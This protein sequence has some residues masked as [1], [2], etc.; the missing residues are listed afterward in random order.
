[1]VVF[2]GLIANSFRVWLLGW[3]LV[4]EYL[5][6]DILELIV[7]IIF[8]VRIFFDGSIII[9]YSLMITIVIHI[10]IFKN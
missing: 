6:G 2:D 5:F 4:G 7:W 8:I 9:V 10:V 3:L 1:M